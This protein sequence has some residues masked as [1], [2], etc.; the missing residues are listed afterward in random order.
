MG[1]IFSLSNICFAWSFSPPSSPL[2]LSPEKSLNLLT[3]N[4]I[5]YMKHLLYN[6]KRGGGD[7][8]SSLGSGFSSNPSD[9]LTLHD[10]WI[11]HISALEIPPVH[12]AKCQQRAFSISFQ[13]PSFKH[14]EATDTRVGGGSKKKQPLWVVN[15][16]FLWR[17][18][19]SFT[20]TG[21]R[22]HF[23]SSP[24]GTKL[25]EDLAKHSVKQCTNHKRKHVIK[26]QHLS[27]KNTQAIFTC[28]KHNS[29]TSCT[30]CSTHKQY[31]KRKQTVHRFICIKSFY[32]K[33]TARYEPKNSKNRAI[34]LTFVVLPWKVCFFR[35]GKSTLKYVRPTSCVTLK[36]FRVFL[37]EHGRSFRVATCCSL[38]F[39]QAGALLTLIG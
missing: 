31:R 26:Q 14:R 7:L 22:L 3:I 23:N 29:N 32:I 18:Y 19:S 5:Y 15:S 6:N 35:P 20:R 38:H 33:A 21:R 34:S 36:Y 9:V 25:G 12:S 2:H 4:K 17:D 10:S 28:S 13:W 27:Y 16:G 1:C 39:L 30:W 24:R 11:A 8:A 37:G